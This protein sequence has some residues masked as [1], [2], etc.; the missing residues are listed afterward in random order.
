MQ[1]PSKFFLILITLLSLTGL[2]FVFEASTVESFKLFGH[3]YYFFKQQAIWLILSFAV[4][5]LASKLKINFFKKFALHFYVLAIFLLILTFIPGIGLK[6]NGASRWISL[7]FGTLQ[8]VEVFK[9]VLINFYA[10]LLSKKLDLSSFLF[11]LFVPI[12]IVLLQPDFGS[13]MILVATSIVMYFLAGGKIK[14]LSILLGAGFF[15]ALAVV[16]LSPYRRERLTT[17]LNP[18]ENVQGDSYHVRQ[19]TL[20]LGGG[21]WFGRGI[22]N[23][24]QKYSYVPE[25][26]SDSI[27]AI[28]AEEVGFIGSFLIISLFALYFI[29]AN[30]MV[31]DKA[32]NKYEYLLYYGILA[33]MAIQLIFNLSAVVVLLPLSGMPLPFFSQG[34]SS[35]LMSF[36]ASGVLLSIASHAKIKK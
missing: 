28:V 6:L 16:L 8:P 19:I 30:L 26:S 33:W 15:L 9:F 12:V 4:L 36:F 20:A 18:S 2:F 13:M 21:S 7:P 3:Q 35:L 14:W 29:L 34:G 32:L 5:F 25:A 27:F 22:G 1:T 31:K 10:Y 17:F 24:Q 23:S 11:F